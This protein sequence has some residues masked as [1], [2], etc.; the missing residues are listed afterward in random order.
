M[1][2]FARGSLVRNMTVLMGGDALAGCLA[3]LFVTLSGPPGNGFSLWRYGFIPVVLLSSF[4]CEV[5]RPD[6]LIFK[7]KLM[8]SGLAAVISLLV[9]LIFL[10][11]GGNGS[12]SLILSLLLFVI[13]QNA[14]QSL[15]QKSTDSLYFA[16]N[17][18][19][20]GTG[21]MAKKVEHL[22]EAYPGRY[23]LLGY[24][25]GG[26]HCRA[27]RHHCRNGKGA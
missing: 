19:V 23:S 27:Y 24:R 16:A 3:L 5:Y 7:V 15:Y 26:G 20:I 22:I 8:R 4:L 21:T 18:L 14:W 1:A 10:K 17:V 2:L 13:L 12:G 9:L 11:I 6:K 25:T